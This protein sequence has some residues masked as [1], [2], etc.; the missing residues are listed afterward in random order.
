MKCTEQLSCWIKAKFVK[1]SILH[2]VIDFQR[3]TAEKTFSK[4]FS[5]FGSFQDLI[6]D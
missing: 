5:V 6:A 4:H 1:M 3:R 2:L